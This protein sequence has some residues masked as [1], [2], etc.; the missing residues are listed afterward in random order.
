MIQLVIGCT[1]GD[2]GKGQ[3]V[4]ALCCDAKQEGKNPIVVRY[5]GGHQ[6]GHTVRIEDNYHI[7]SCFGSG[8]FAGCRTYWTEHTVMDPIR[9]LMEYSELRRKNIV[10]PLQMFNPFT[11]ITTPF[12]VG[13]NKD[14]RIGN[15]VGCGI[16]ETVE[17]DR[18]GLSIYVKDLAYPH[19]LRAKLHAIKE[20]SRSKCSQASTWFEL[21]KVDIENLISIYQQFH[22]EISVIDLNLFEEK[23]LI[24]E[25]SQ[26]IL[27][28]P[29]YGLGGH[30]VTTPISLINGL[31]YH[32]DE[33]YCVY[34][35]YLTRHGNGPTCGAMKKPINNI[36][37]TNVINTYQGEFQTFE[38]HK[39]LVTYGIDLIQ[40]L[41]DPEKL[42][43]IETCCDVNS[44]HD[45]NTVFTKV[46]HSNDP[47]LNSICKL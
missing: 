46:L 34:R 37:E 15:T 44:K 17:R 38:F 42:I 36:Y 28:D 12:D 47:K 1:F 29:E 16:W 9:W 31:H 25:S 26:G 11:K 14:R 20:Y 5:S 19:I 21:E 10:I 6:A 7:F 39:E 35:S 8:T 3:I 23:D 40:S 33:A 4:H 22:Y 43:C 13:L 18:V 24:Y 32:I 41:I 27:L 30:N 45:L 2:E